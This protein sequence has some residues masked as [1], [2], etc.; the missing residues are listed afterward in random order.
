[1]ARN[2]LG[3]YFHIPFCQKK[4]AYCDFYSVTNFDDFSRYT[5]SLLLQ[6]EDWSKDCSGYEADTVF[7]GGG[8]PTALPKKNMI[9]LINGIYRNFKVRRDAEFTMEANPASIDYQTLKKYRA[10]GVNRLSIGLQSANDRELK[11]LTR[12]HSFSDFCNSFAAARKAGFDNINVDVMYGI[13]MQTKATLEKTL[14]EVIRLGPEHISLYGLK[15]EEGTPFAKHQD[16]LVLPDEETE[17]GMYIS[18]IDK[19]AQNGYTQY[20]ISNFAKEGYECRH[21]LKYWNCEEY[22]GFGPAAHSYFADRRF[23]YK[24]SVKMFMDALEYPDAGLNILEEDYNINRF[25]RVDE[26]IML[27][28]RL[29]RGIDEQDFRDHFEFDFGE[30]YAKELKMYLDN[31]FMKH[32]D[33]RYFFTPKGMYVSNYI[34]SSFLTFESGIADNIAKGLDK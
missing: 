5:D 33:G 29:N 34:L 2:K 18:S 1:M 26:Y 21:N 14:S 12:I 4:C 30:K 15:I 22:L 20:E 16:K 31:G 11:G 9:E 24:R 13:P 7:I 19:L 6:M 32:E 10:M 28:L 3:L 25:E 23:S 17:Y 27:Q 8:T